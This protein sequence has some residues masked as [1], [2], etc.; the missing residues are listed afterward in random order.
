MTWANKITTFLFNLKLP[1]KLSNGISVLDVHKNEEVK[2]ACIEFY[3]KFYNDNN[4]RYLLIGINPG[5]FGGGITGLPFTDPIRL[6]NDCGINNEWQ[7]K[8]ELSSV[9]MYE[10]MAAYGGV[11]LF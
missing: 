9:F 5:R 8:Q 6:Q 11:K 7:K 1:L 2:K 10:M 4:K 3:N